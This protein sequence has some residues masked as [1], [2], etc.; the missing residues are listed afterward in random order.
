MK[1]AELLKPGA[2]RGIATATP[3]TTATHTAIE[4]GVTVAR[5]ATVAVAKSIDDE[6]VT[7]LMLA[8]AC[9]LT[10]YTLEQLPEQ[11]RADLLARDDAS[12]EY[13]A[14]VIRDDAEWF[15]WD[16]RSVALADYAPGGRFYRADQ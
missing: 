15:G 8:K 1:L 6:T 9:K 7:A 4:A 2:L 3:A 11:L 13:M 12:A 5:V 14:H 10:G 16:G